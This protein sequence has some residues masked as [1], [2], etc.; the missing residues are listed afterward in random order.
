MICGDLGSATKRD[1]KLEHKGRAWGKF[2]SRTLPTHIELAYPKLQCVFRFNDDQTIWK[3]NR[4]V[5]GVTP[6]IYFLF[7]QEHKLRGQG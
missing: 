2:L 6:K 3:L 7:L 1:H 5:H 4:Y